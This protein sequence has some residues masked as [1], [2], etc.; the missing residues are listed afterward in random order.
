MICHKVERYSSDDVMTFHFKSLFWTLPFRRHPVGVERCSIRNYFC[1]KGR[2]IQASKQQRHQVY[3]LGRCLVF[4]LRA[5]CW[6]QEVVGWNPAGKEECQ[7]E[8]KLS[9]AAAAAAAA[10]VSDLAFVN[11]NLQ[12]NY[13]TRVFQISKVGNVQLSCWHRRDG[14]LRTGMKRQ[15][16]NWMCFIFCADRPC[17]CAILLELLSF[18]KS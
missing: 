12:S 14:S 11:G 18:L 15:E 5:R 6:G 8:S 10:A 13:S 2:K 9:L 4:F 1:G 17:L 7:D 3:H 16:C